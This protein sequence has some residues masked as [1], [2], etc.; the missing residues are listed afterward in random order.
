MIPHLHWPHLPLF[1]MTRVRQRDTSENGGN[2]VRRRQ[3]NV[4]MVVSL[5][6][7]TVVVATAAW[8][9][10]SAA[11]RLES[12]VVTLQASSLAQTAVLVEL[13][14]KVDGLTGKA[15]ASQQS[16]LTQRTDVLR[17]LDAIEQRVRPVAPPK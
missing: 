13:Q 12:A 6:T 9:I 3:A 14:T 15:Q 11:A 1:L 7:G 5:I 8:T 2:G 16:D 4:S 10:V 17:R